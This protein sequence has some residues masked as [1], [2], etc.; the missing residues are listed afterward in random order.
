MTEPYPTSGSTA[1]EPLQES[2]PDPSQHSVGELFGEVAKDLSTL[3]RQEIELAKAEVKT[4]AGKA[5]KAVGMLGGAGYAGHLAVLF[6]SL[7]LLGLLW[8]FLPFGWAALIVAVLWGIV[9]AVLASQ[10]RSKLKQVNPKPEQTVETI[11]EDVEW[12]KHPTR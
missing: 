8:S 7:A 10:G 5:G 12:A 9:A 1:Y 3:I 11:K 2:G 4:E 6:L